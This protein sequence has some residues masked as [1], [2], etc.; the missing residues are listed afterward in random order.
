[1][2]KYVLMLLLPAFF[3]FSAASCSKHHNRDAV[4]DVVVKEFDKDNQKAEDVNW[5]PKGKNFEAKYEEEGIEKVAI[6]SS[7]GKK[8][9]VEYVVEEKEVPVVVSTRL[10]KNYPTMEMQEIVY[11]ERPRHKPVYLVKVKNPRAITQVEINLAGVIVSTV[12]LKS[13]V[14]TVQPVEYEHEHDD[15]DKHHKHKHKHNHHEGHGK[16]DHHE[17]EEV[18]YVKF[19]D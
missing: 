14:V 9:R 18:L 15:C 11:V 16:H 17:D 7:K 4:P 2:K 5:E 6:Y 12:V 13:F 19:K 8:I 10:K 3:I 1:M